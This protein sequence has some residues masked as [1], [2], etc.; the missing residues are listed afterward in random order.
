M[1]KAFEDQD[2]ENIDHGNRPEEKRKIYHKTKTISKLLKKAKVIEG[3]R[4][5]TQ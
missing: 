4:K 2:K 1:K 3:V 5:L